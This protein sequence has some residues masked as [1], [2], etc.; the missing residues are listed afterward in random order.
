[1]KETVYALVFLVIFWKIKDKISLKC[2]QL[3]CGKVR[4]HVTYPYSK[5]I[6]GDLFCCSDISYW[7][8]Q[9]FQ[10]FETWDTACV[11]FKY[12]SLATLLNFSLFQ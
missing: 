8:F 2:V 7:P 12:I 1:M 5:K 11:S 4:G 9:I 10:P 3:P 6:N